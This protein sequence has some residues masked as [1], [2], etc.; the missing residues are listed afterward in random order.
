[1]G[2]FFTPAFAVRATLIAVVAAATV[3]CLGQPRSGENEIGGRAAASVWSDRRLEVEDPAATEL[4]RI[5]AEAAVVP[6]FFQDDQIPATVMDDIRRIFR[7]G[8]RLALETPEPLPEEFE[9]DF[10]KVFLS[11]RELENRRAHKA[12]LQDSGAG[13]ARADTGAGTDARARADVRAGAGA[14]GSRSGTK[15]GLVANGSRASSGA[16]RQDRA[17]APPADASAGALGVQEGA[18]RPSPDPQPL[19]E[20]QALP[21]APPAAGASASLMDNAPSGAA[22]EVAAAPSGKHPPAA[23][24]PDPYSSGGAES[25]PGPEAASAAAAPAAAEVKAGSGPQPQADAAP[26][27]PAGAVSGPQA[28]G[29]PDLQAGTE[30]R[31]QAV[32]APDRQT[33]AAHETPA[34]GPPP[35]GGA[36]RQRTA[37][38]PP[39]PRRNRASRPGSAAPGPRQGRAGPLDYYPDTPAMLQDDTAG[40]GSLLRRTARA[41]F[42]EQLERS[43]TM[44]A[45]E[46]LGQGLVEERPDSPSFLGKQVTLTRSGAQPAMVSFESFLTM[47]R[48]RAYLIPRA[49]MQAADTGTF[50]GLIID[51]VTSV[52]RPNVTLDQATYS[53]RQTDAALTAQPVVYRVRKGELIVREGD[54]I[55]PRTKFI[56]D[57][58]AA[59][60]DKGYWIKRSA[61]LLVILLVFL[62]VTQAVAGM[63]RRRTSGFREALLMAFLLLGCIFMAW[64]SVRLGSG[65]EK[66]FGLAHP[67]TLFLAMPFP[68][69]AML[70]VIFL[71]N[72]RTVPVAFLGAILG[73]VLSPMDTFGAFVYLANGSLVTVL[74]LRHL[75]ERGKFLSASLM[76]ALTN[77]LTILGLSL[78]DG[79][80]A[81]SY[82]LLA[83]AVSG[84]LSGILASG[85]VPAVELLMGFTTN[86]KL[87]E[88]GNLNR[89]LLREL[90]LAAPG[91]Y[92]HS[93]IV[94]SMVEAAAEAIGAN[95]HLARV[96]AYYHDIGKIRKPLYFIE[97]QSG[98]N[99]HDS[100]TPT[101]SV[102]ILI[103]HVKDGVEIARANMLP[104]EV[105]DIVEQHH[106]TSLMSFFLHKAVEGRSPNSPPVNPGDFRYPGPKPASKEAG[107][108]MLADICE[109]ATR[110][111]TEP[112]PAKI[113]ELVR[114]LI[115]RIFDDGQLDSSELV[116]RDLTETMR[117]FTNILVGIYHHRI[118]YP[119]INKAA[120]K[121]QAI[122]SKE[123]YG[124]LAADTAAA[125]RVTH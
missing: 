100:L 106:G 6:V 55:T 116:L 30:A 73:A 97:N 103:G 77:I 102:L 11:G 72:R 66:G 112:T 17:A 107:L 7:E 40:P 92:H 114:A 123:I 88:L 58:L 91:T 57:A 90:M 60:R 85:L 35:A 65:F 47:S 8:R 43:V 82:D 38:A 48:A 83:G 69:A 46:L 96:G 14:G 99:R 49:R 54:I 26:A 117:I 3:Y 2:A 93:V 121:T 101:M 51:L 36:G 61:G 113:Q 56:L 25:A 74:R 45:V 53:F 109:A 31:P 59:D 70:A 41:G 50:P 9:D 13:G 124:S 118:T 4:E 71:G 81:V 27:Q 21:G 111:L 87:M 94:G 63:E 19:A 29:E 16:S 15:D 84:I 105:V 20:T 42:S 18:G 95:P 78:M 80:A 52:L 37:A 75:S 108:V 32:N 28:G 122:R 44:L 89:P 119:V 125:K 1:M 115:N 39:E 110:S 98:E 86:L 79:R 68:A 62:T 12:A 67:H 23:G 5:R 64:A 120:A 104:P 34:A 33:G 22:A 24:E 10:Y 76:C